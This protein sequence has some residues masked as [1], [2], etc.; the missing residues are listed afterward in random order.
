MQCPAKFHHAQMPRGDLIDDP[1]VEQDDAIGHILFQPVA[2][3]LI[4]SALGRDDGR[5]A[6]FLEP[7]EKPSQLGS[8]DGLI[9]QAGEKRF[10]R[11]QDD[12]LGADGVYRRIETDEQTFEVIVAAFPDF[13][14]L[15]MDV[16]DHDLFAPNQAG[17]IETERRNVRLQLRFRLL[18][19]HQDARFTEACRT[20]NEKLHGKQRLA[21]PCA[22]ADQCGTPPRQSAI[23]DFIQTLNARGTPR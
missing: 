3:E 7:A 12:A 18:E 1:V 13:T 14:A 19:G 2:G 6:F 23:R 17:K 8:K 11:V 16:V 10:K 15:K 20:S 21:A 9:G 5:H 4:A 22:A